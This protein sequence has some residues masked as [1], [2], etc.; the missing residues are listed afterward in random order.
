MT[1]RVGVDATGW[2]NQRG[3]GRF[4]RNAVAALASREGLDIELF[5]DDSVDAESLPARARVRRI[6]SGRPAVDAATA[7]S[8][9][10]VRDML[11]AGATVRASP[12]D[13]MLFPSLHTWFPARGVPSVVG[14]HDAIAKRYPELTFGTTSA[15][16][17]WSLKEHAAIR[18]ATRVFTVSQAACADVADAFGLDPAGIAVVPE[19]PDPVFTRPT[20]PSLRTLLAA[21]GLQPDRF[22]LCAPGG[23][24]PHKGV[25]TAV[26]AYARLREADSALAP[27][28]VVGALDDDAYHSASAAVVELISGL[29]LGRSVVLPGF[30][31]DETLAALYAGAIAVVNPSRAEG[32]GLPAVEAA[33]CGAAVVLSDIPAHRETLGGAAVFF[34]VG[35]VEEL[36]AAIGSVAGD[37]GI[38]ADVARRCEAAVSM[39]SW[40]ATGEQ[41]AVVLAEAAGRA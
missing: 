24:S 2:A 4:A 20:D 29:G 8:R 13:V 16:L 15:R 34:T 39:L 37:S 30:V 28:V 18:A 25:E 10:S 33:S 19:A 14:V 35:D 6:S 31:P 41:L 12:L 9:R 40:A 5:V 21:L 23:I 22:L 1:I 27:L 11:R 26:R 32:F 17:A 7:G 36:A 38:R 3:F